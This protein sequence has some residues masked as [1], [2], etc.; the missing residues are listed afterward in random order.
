MGLFH[1]AHLTTY[2]R[3]RYIANILQNCRSL[4]HYFYFK[5]SLYIFYNASGGFLDAKRRPSLS[6]S[7]TMHTWFWWSCCKT[8]MRILR[9][10]CFEAWIRRYFNHVKSFWLFL[11]FT[12]FGK[13]HKNAALR[14]TSRCL[15][16]SL[17]KSCLLI[18]TAWV[19]NQW[20]IPWLC[21]RAS[22]CLINCEFLSFY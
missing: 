18:S 20:P 21:N 13:R 8:T 22:S 14:P 9:L 7:T 5:H 4:L 6:V 12:L 10:Q 19:R 2:R 16:R 17:S 1:I 15:K 3:L 11:F